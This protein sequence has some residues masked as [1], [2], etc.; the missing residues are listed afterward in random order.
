[1][2][3]GNRSPVPV[4]RAQGP[5][6]VAFPEELTSTL[7]SKQGS[8][9]HDADRKAGKP[10]ICMRT[11]LLLSAGGILKLQEKIRSYRKPPRRGWYEMCGTDR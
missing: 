7:M 4:G 8:E 2:R 10:R 6:R 3:T 5:S 11:R 1:M 9:S